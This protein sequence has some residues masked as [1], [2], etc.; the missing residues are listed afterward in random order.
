MFRF[1]PA[2]NKISAGVLASLRSF[3][4]ARCDAVLLLKE[5]LPLRSSLHGYKLCNR[6][7]RSLDYGYVGVKMDRTDCRLERRRAANFG[8]LVILPVILGF[9]ASIEIVRKAINVRCKR[10]ENPTDILAQLDATPS[11]GRKNLLKRGNLVPG[12]M[13]AI[14]DHAIQ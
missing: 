14:V 11:Q 1:S 10:V 13:A 3:V 12:E 6:R 5:W 4:R 9:D 8:S 7:N 2:A